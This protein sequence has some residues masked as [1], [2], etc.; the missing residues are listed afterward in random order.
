MTVYVEYA[1]LDNFTMDFLLLFFSATTLKIRF[2]WWRLALG[3]TVGTV[4]ALLT[5]YLNGVILCV[6]K[7]FCL[8]AMCFVSIGRGKK[9]FWHILLTLTYTFVT[10]G[11][12][13]GI[14][15][16]LNVDYT[17]QDGFYYNM[18]VPLFVY[19]LAVAAVV[20]MCYA[21]HAFVVKSKQVA[22]FLQKIVL[23]LDK[24][25]DMCG[26]CDSGNSV[27][28][29][30][31]PVCFLAKRNGHIAECFAEKIL[32]GESVSVEVQ[33]LVGRKSVVA[34]DATLE[35]HGKKHSILLAFSP[36]KGQTQYDVILNSVFCDVQEK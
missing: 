12:I 33:T 23:H 10:G 4:V 2:R 18:P 26:L 27:V 25:Y 9:L 14:F 36:V 8:F 24:S 21:V 13:V 3:A 35:M 31:V 17:T 16:L 6:A 7:A 5:V 15:N 32:C 30:G 34:I 11:A 20:V 28:Q 22:P 29:N 1:F 19:F